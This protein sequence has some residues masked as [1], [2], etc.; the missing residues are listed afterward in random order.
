MPSKRHPFCKYE[1][2][3]LRTYSITF[4]RTDISCM[5]NETAHT[6]CVNSGIPKEVFG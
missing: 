1:L 2:D 5:D 3:K 6:I 4:H